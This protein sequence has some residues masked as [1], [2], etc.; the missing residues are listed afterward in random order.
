MSDTQGGL[1]LTGLER[2]LVFNRL[3]ATVG[4]RWELRS[5][6]DGLELAPQS[7]CLEIGAG[8]GWGTLGL[9]RRYDSVQVI[10]TDYDATILPTTR[11]YLSQHGAL[12]HVVFARADAKRLPF[13]D[14]AFDLV[15][16]LY[17]LHHVYGYRQ[18][19]NELGRVTKPG[20]HFLFIDMLRAPWM[21]RFRRWV[22]PDGAPSREELGGLL[23]EAGFRIER[24]RGLPIWA[25]VAARRE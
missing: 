5:L 22:P 7:L 4:L 14:G 15:L 20:G 8:R 24:W 17:V 3:R 16:A 11:A 23:A 18:A 9:I 25:L 12:S 10:A 1:P 13:Q 21:P 19:L 2:G 6:F